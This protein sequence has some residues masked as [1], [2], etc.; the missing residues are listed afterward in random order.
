MHALQPTQPTISRTRPSR[1]FAG[2]SGSVISARVIPSASAPPAPISRSAT[3][4]SIIREVAI[5]GGPSANGSVFAA[6]AAS[7]TGGGGTIPTEPRYVAESPSA[8]ER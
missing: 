7:S 5:R 2:S 3:S 1:A 8:S 6:I 4:T